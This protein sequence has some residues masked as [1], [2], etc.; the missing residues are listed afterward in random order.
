MSLGRGCS[1]CP[2]L[3]L[4]VLRQIAQI[5]GMRSVSSQEIP[6]DG[7]LSSLCYQHKLNTSHRHHCSHP[8]Y[9]ALPHSAQRSLAKKKK[10]ETAPIFSKDTQVLFFIM[11]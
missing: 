1:C 2:G 10:K 11:R 8:V 4:Q 3:L 5:V 9:T 7:A 6:A